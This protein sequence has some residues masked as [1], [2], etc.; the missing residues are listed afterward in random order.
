MTRLA[1]LAGWLVGAIASALLVWS[2]VVYLLDEFDRG[3]GRDTW[4]A[5]QLYISALSI[6]IGFIG[7]VVVVLFRSAQGTFAVACVAGV[8]FGLFQLLFV[9]VLGRAFPDRDMVAHGLAGTLVIG[10]LS[11]LALCPNAA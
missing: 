9:F 10:A 11:V 5:L 2:V 1:H 3:Y 4:F 8:A 7:Y 6:V